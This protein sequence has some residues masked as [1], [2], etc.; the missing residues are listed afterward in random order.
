MESTK[1]VE[2]LRKTRL[3]NEEL[4][5]LDQSFIIVPYLISGYQDYGNTGIINQQKFVNDYE[6]FKRI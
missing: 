6:T 4:A 5:L 3:R 1:I 2:S